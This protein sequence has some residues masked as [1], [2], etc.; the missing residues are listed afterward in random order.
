MPYKLGN[1][2]KHYEWGSPGYIP[3]LLGLDNS[4]GEPWAELWMGV[5]PGAPSRV[6]RGEEEIP[7]AELIAEDPALYLGKEAAERFGGLPFLFKLL[8]A[9]KPLSIQAHPNLAQAREGF[10]RENR[11][12]IALDAPVRN[13]RDPNHKPEIV[14]ALTPFTAMFGFREPGEIRGLFRAVFAAAPRRLREGLGPLE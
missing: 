11:A 6:L 4:G 5:H 12:G 10:E 9:G 14:C 2:V 3:R 13:Y 8:A 1:S 7:L